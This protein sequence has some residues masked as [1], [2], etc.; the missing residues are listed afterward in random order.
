M[1]GGDMKPANVTL[2]VLAALLG[3]FVARQ[4]TSRLFGPQ[5]VSSAAA[6]GKVAAD[7]NKGL[8]MMLNKDI[9]LVTTIGLDGMFIYK[10]RLVDRSLDAIDVPSFIAGVRPEVV[11][12]ACTIDLRKLLDRGVVVQYVYVDRDGRQ[13]ADIR[14]GAKD[15]SK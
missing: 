12:T 7:I 5:D 6:L 13:V 8:P 1:E 2:G 10:A 9:E 14:V 15:C 3:A 4:A 11:N